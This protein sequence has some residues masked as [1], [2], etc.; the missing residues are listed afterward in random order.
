MLLKLW[1]YE[2][3]NDGGVWPHIK[4]VAI[5]EYLSDN[6]MLTMKTCGCATV[7]CVNTRDF[8]DASM[9][10]MDELNDNYMW[11]PDGMSESII[12]WIKQ[13]RSMSKEK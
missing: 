2:S 1:L 12:D 4:S 5:Q 9:K 3:Y 8:V 11:E 13:V 10:F 6:G 7:F